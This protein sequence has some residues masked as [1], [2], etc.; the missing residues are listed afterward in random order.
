MK[1]GMGS[2]LRENTNTIPICN[3]FTL[4]IEEAF[5]SIANIDNYNIYSP[6][7][8]TLLLLQGNKLQI[9]IDK[10]STKIEKDTIVVGRVYYNNK[11]LIQLKKEKKKGKIEITD[12][13]YTLNY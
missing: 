5:P 8:E 10:I 9:N 13:D 6:N 4:T 12:I 3:K 11:S 7:E 1:T 2:D